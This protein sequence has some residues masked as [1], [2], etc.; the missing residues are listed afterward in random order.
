MP[1]QICQVDPKAFQ[2]LQ[3]CIY[4]GDYDTCEAVPSG[5]PNGF[6]INPIA[7]FG[8]DMNGAARWVGGERG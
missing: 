2:A 8:V 3:D 5:D 6:L 7:G 4:C 1:C